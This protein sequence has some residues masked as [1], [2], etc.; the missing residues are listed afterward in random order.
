VTGDAPPLTVEQRDGHLVAVLSRPATRNAI[1]LEVVERLHELCRTLEQEPQVLVLTGAGP[2]FAAGG[3]IGELRERKPPDA[4]AGINSRVFDRIAH[5]PM[6]TV[7][8]VNGPAVGGGAELAYACDLRVA[9]D[10][11]FF[12][13]PE[14]GLGI[15]AAAGGCWRLKELVG[16]AVA[17]QVLLAGRRLSAQEA[18]HHGLVSA[19]VAPDELEAATAEVVATLLAASAMALRLTK[20]A[21]QAPLSAHPAFDEVAQA[22]LFGSADARERMTAFLTRKASR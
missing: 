9:S 12:G 4:L 15:I 17:A 19:V 6:P 11:A 14:V 20:A 16:G 7:A 13:N 2:V 22:V 1:D 18:L 5:L 21:M 3:D 8:A 10:R